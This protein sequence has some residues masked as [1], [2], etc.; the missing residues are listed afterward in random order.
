[1]GR[2]DSIHYLRGVAALL[3]VFY[4]FKGFINGVYPIE[5]LGNLLFGVGAFGVDLFFIISGFIICFATKNKEEK[6][7]RKFVIRRFFRIYPLL[8]VCVLLFYFFVLKV[9]SVQDLLTSL[10]P[11]N[12]DYNQNGPFFGCNILPPAWT[13]TFEIFFYS[14]FLLSMT[15]NHRMRGIIVVTIII[16]S[17]FWLQK[18]A[19]GEFTLDPSSNY[20]FGTLPFFLSAIA[21]TASSPMMIG[22][23]CGVVIYLLWERINFERLENHKNTFASI[24]LIILMICISLL[25][26]GQYEGH[27][28]AKWGWI[29]ALIV[30]SCLIIEGCVVIKQ[31]RI[32]SFMGDIS[33]SLYITHLVFLY[34]ISKKEFFFHIYKP[35][36]GFV[37]VA[38]FVS[39]S[40]LMAYIFHRIIEVPSIKLG[41][42]ILRK[43]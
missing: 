3:V 25:W 4:H 27:G 11:L 35:Y 39:C 5:N 1:M 33:Y 21:S 32:L 38:V 12:R 14:L 28:F 6:Q 42:I 20:G 9:E 30:I 37:T 10:I 18:F 24:S 43:I 8:I 41:K 17:M 29:A 15:I 22:F 31:N 13:I 16:L 2:I 23:V 7:G 26:S 19:T 34:A 40:I 36:P